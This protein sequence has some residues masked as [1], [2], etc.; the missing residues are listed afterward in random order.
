MDSG[1]MTNRRL[2]LGGLATTLAGCASGRVPAKAAM[3]GWAQPALV[4]LEATPARL[5]HMT[6]CLR[7]FRAA[8]P[9][10]DVEQLGAKRIVHN[11]GHGGSGWSLSWGSAALA[12]AR[13]L[14]GGPETLGV[15]GCGVIGITT[16]LTLQRSGR[17]VTIYAAEMLPES[18]SAR[19]TGTW[20]PSSRIADTDAAGAD[21]PVRWEAMARVSL[22]AWQQ[23]VGLA[24]SPVAWSK[25]YSLSDSMADSPRPETPVKFAHLDQRMADAL[26]ASR[27]LDAAENPFSVA[28][29]RMGIS[30]QFNIAELSRQLVAEFHAAGGRIVER[31]FNS[32]AELASL[33]EPVIVNCTG[34]GAAALWNDKSLVPVRGQI[35][36]L[37]AQPGLDYGV[38]YRGAIMLPRPEGIVV[39]Q[40]GTS[41]MYGYGITEEKADRAEAEAAIATLAGLWRS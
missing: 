13:A 11:Y 14:E 30:M 19:A 36:W 17:Q 34:Y 18:R 12:A 23:R 22:R 9:R 15:I 35:S 6:V 32:P 29:A 40:T 1:L 25:R 3:A 4:P 27:T 38:T 31:R 37:A 10:L 16:A 7:P 5:T 26:P 24:G 20:S 28:R 33:P 8:G 2:L 39:L 41:E 21:F